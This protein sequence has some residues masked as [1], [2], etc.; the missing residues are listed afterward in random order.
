L[1]RLGFV[2]EVFVSIQG[3]G[4]YVG[5]LQLFVR[6]AGCSLGCSYCDTVESWEKTESCS[7]IGYGKSLTNPVEAKSFA[8]IVEEIAGQTQAIHSISVTGGEPLEQPDFLESFLHLIGRT[9]KPRY[10][11]TNGLHPEA[12]E[13]VIDLV[14]IIS[15]DIKLPSLCGG[16]DLFPIY[17]V[18]LPLLRGKEMFCKIVIG[19]GFDRDDFDKAIEMLSGFDPAVR[20]VIQPM[21][22]V[23]DHLPVEGDTLIDLH[24]RASVRLGNVRII[25]QCHR[26][27]DVK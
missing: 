16:E 24:E 7:L 20:L 3:E 15:L 19:D 13:R 6:L 12:L 21:T 26:I 18:T 17:E 5:F 10:L 11:E 8:S 4:L 22:T 2:S 25:P 27:L 23:R 9:G 14:E 1:E